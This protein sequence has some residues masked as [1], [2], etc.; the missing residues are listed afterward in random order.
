[1]RAEMLMRQDPNV[2]DDG[3][4]QLG[5][6][7]YMQQVGLF[8]K[9]KPKPVAPPIDIQRRSI[10]GL[11]PQAPLPDNLP[12]V[13]SSDVPVPNAVPQ[14]VWA[15]GPF[16]TNADYANVIKKHLED[17]Q[18]EN[19][20]PLESMV[21]KAAKAPITRR[22]LIKKAGQVVAN[23][24][25]PMPNVTKAASPLAE[26]AKAIA[27]VNDPF[28][29]VSKNLQDMTSNLISDMTTN[30][31]FAGAS[32]AYTF[33]REYLDGRVSKKTLDAM[34][35]LQLKVDTYYDDD[36]N[37]DAAHKRQSKLEDFVHD[38]M[39]YLKPHEL[40]DITNNI[41]QEDTSPEEWYTQISEER[42]GDIGNLTPEQFKA[43][44]EKSKE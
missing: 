16:A 33:M 19:A 38:S 17:R 25:L 35:K 41:I 40:H 39:K 11:K 42:G 29:N 4:S 8:G 30:E 15:G 36:D 44:I 13:R 5:M 20:A 2:Y 22:E 26:A 1:M 18:A 32:A 24:A 10:L 7:P 28:A 34:D 14:N 3:A 27:P 12:A 43:Y 31:P 21:N 9:G 6:S 23:Q 37:S